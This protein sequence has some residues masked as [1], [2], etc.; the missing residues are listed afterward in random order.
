[1]KLNLFKRPL[2]QIERFTHQENIKDVF[3]PKVVGYCGT[4]FNF[5]RPSQMPLYL[6]IPQHP[7]TIS[8]TTSMWDVSFVLRKDQT[9][10]HDHFQ[11]QSMC[12]QTDCHT[13]T[14]CSRKIEKEHF[15]HANL[16]YFLQPENNGRRDRERER[17]GETIKTSR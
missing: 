5:K 13:A 12:K 4:E 2:L 14:Q 15:E 6:I 8:L 16:Y 9:R 7:L 3:T 10:F 1:M 17:E 11:L